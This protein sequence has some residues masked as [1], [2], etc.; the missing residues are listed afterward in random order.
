M[1]RPCR[2]R[3]SILHGKEPRLR[4]QTTSASGP[5]GFLSWRASESLLKL[6]S[7]ALK[8]RSAGCKCGYTHV[9]LISEHWRFLLFIHWLSTLQQS[10]GES[11]PGVPEGGLFPLTLMRPVDGQSLR[12]SET[13]SLE[14]SLFLLLSLSCCS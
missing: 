3:G 13:T 12:Q 9:G 8:L 2:P 11:A 14:L 7:P 6:P 10:G 4:C 5:E 1:G